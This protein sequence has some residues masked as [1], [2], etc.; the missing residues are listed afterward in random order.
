MAGGQI[1]YASPEH[2]Y[3][4]PGGSTTAGL[5]D[6]VVAAKQHGT[7]IHRRHRRSRREPRDVRRRGD[8]VD[9]FAMDE[10]DGN[11]ACTT[12]A[13]WDGERESEAKSS[14]SRRGDTLD[15]RTRRWTRRGETIQSVRFLGSVGAVVTFRRTDPLHDRCVGPDEPAR[16]R[17]LKI[18]GFSATTRRRREAARD[19][20]GR[21]RIRRAARNPVRSST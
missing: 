20:S 10:H 12:G 19:R 17:Q 16:C 1:V 5:P 11:R 21:D 7:D 13:P 9:Q 4:A 18:L 3:A 6:A 14:C 15:D 2:L 8:L